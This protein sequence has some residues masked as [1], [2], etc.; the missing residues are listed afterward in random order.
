MFNQVANVESPSLSATYQT[1]T[2]RF[3]YHLYGRFAQ[4]SYLWV[5]LSYG[6]TKSY[7][8]S[9]SGNQGDKWIKAELGLGSV[10][11][12]EKKNRNRDESFYLCKFTSEFFF[13]I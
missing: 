8:W 11:A 4:H 13:A 12:G 7:I 1:C 10:P 5:G 9:T 2:V 6:G 3:Y